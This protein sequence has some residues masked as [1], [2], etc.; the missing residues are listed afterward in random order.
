MDS[1]NTYQLS[2][3]SFG[4][5]DFEEPVEDRLINTIYDF[6]RYIEYGRKNDQNGACIV[7]TGKQ[8]V[9]LKNNNGGRAGHAG[10]FAR[11]YLEME[12]DHRPL[13][14]NESIRVIAP[15]ERNY[16]T[17]TF[18]AEMQK[19]GVIYYQVRLFINGSISPQE[20]SSFQSFYDQFAGIISKIPFGF[21]VSDVEKQETFNLDNLDELLEFLKQR[22]DYN[23][24]PYV[25]PNGEQIIGC[26]NRQKQEGKVY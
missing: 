21:F 11:I 23:K 6:S 12:G 4:N 24:Q 18:E 8:F 25:S 7:F 3:N 26:P 16:L 17:M 1:Y 9:F 10:C 20:L 13:T 22:T 19:P 5:G 2:K 15:R 14:Y